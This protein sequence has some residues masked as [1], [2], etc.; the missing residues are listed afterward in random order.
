MGREDLYGRAKEVFLEVC[1]RSGPDRDTALAEL[2]AGDADLRGEVEAL[3]SHDA[4]GDGMD[5][6]GGRAPGDRL[7][8]YTIVRVL[9]A[10][11][12]GVVYEAEQEHPR[13]TV[14]IKIGRA[15][16]NA[17]ALRDRL[18]HEV[19]ALA[20]LQHPG[21][22][23][24]Y[25]TGV[26]PDTGEPYFVMEL[27][28]GVP[29]TTYARDQGLTPSERVALLAGVCDAVH[30]AHLRGVIHRDLKP[31]N[32]LVDEFGRAR[33]LDFGIARLDGPDDAG[34]TLPGQ[35]MGTLGYMSPEQAAG[36]PASIDARTDI[37]ALGSI[38]YELLA[39]RPPLTL[40][41][42]PIHEAVRAIREDDPPRLGL[43]DRRSRGDME[44]IAGTALEKDPSRRYQSAAAL[45]DD[46]RRALRN[47]PITARAPT[48]IYQIARFARRRRGLVVATG[49]I[50]ATLVAAT[51][52]S[53]AFAVRAEADRTRAENDRTQAEAD[54]AR[55]ERRFAQ[56]R[57]LANTFL[58]DIHDRIETLPGS[59]DARRS[60][61]ATGLTYLDSLAEE[62][63][64]DPGL[65]D[66]L[67]TAYARIGDL[68]GN[69]RRSNLGDAEAALGS[70]TRSIEIRRR[71]DRL[72]PSPE[73][74]LEM[75]RTLILSGEAM[76]SSRRS[77][78]EAVRRF[79]DARDGLAAMLDEHPDHTGVLDAIGLAESRL[80][81]VLREMGRLD[82]ALARFESALDAA[83]RVERIDPGQSR[84]RSVA[85]N[86]VGM[87][88]VRLG[89]AEEA[90]PH[91]E[92][93]MRIRTEAVEREPESTRAQRDL[94]LV[95]HRLADV[96]RSTGDPVGAL[97]HDMAALR[98]LAA[99]QRAEP[100]DARARFDL[101]V[102][103]TKTADS[104]DDLGRS[105][106]AL[107]AWERSLVLRR[108]LMRDH[109]TNLLYAKAHCLSMERVADQ[110]RIIGRHDEAVDHFHRAIALAEACNASDPHDTRIWGAIAQSQR[111][112]GESLLTRAD[113]EADPDRDA[114]MRTEAA[115]WFRACLGT[116]N[117]MRDNGFTPV[118][119][120]MTHAEL[121]ALLARCDP[122]HPAHAPTPP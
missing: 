108:D 29:I 104:L 66:E 9:G 28:R 61:I 73:N 107:A 88:L 65:L 46:L 44:T 76:T 37:Y 71:I 103:E 52:V 77:S 86:E 85:H 114:S 92:T 7:G 112:I 11:S 26:D 91:Y 16:V 8:R 115:A 19:A 31:S 98:T 79:T 95:H 38:L 13:R 101:S 40:G 42:L 58:F 110:L 57:A 81:G 78:D 93:S 68:Q 118:Q 15:G 122:I 109:P 117:H 96:R 87:T 97:G 83:I 3:L 120:R 6:A 67:A 70:F 102:A 35:V 63:G 22:A 27:V 30:H 55:A 25:D 84:I 48:T 10:G 33:V 100:E 113:A 119:S 89:R 121:D 82:E 75:L 12:M 69:P 41:G 53:A 34:A 5:V 59:L 39:G 90:L 62:A 94:A 111:G 21:I 14:A 105:E 99:L 49:A 18:A 36:D 74:R 1:D 20:R 51:V 54:R 50:A 24:V 64:D 32:I 72:D 56:V 60:L 45:A 43:L 80:G 4:D 2:C 47:E 23:A 17:S 106:E 116:L